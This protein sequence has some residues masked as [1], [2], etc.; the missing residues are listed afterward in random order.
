MVSMILCITCTACTEV[1]VMPQ[2]RLT[3][4]MAPGSKKWIVVGSLCRFGVSKWGRVRQF[5]IKVC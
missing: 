1:W 5:G 4:E 3:K 2:P